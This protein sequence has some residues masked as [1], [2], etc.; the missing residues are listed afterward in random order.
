VGRFGRLARLPVDYAGLAWWGLV[1]PRVVER[2][3]LVVLQAV[4]CSEQGV[5]LAL[6]RELQGWELPGGVACP[7]ETDEEAVRREVHEETGLEVRVGS[8]SG[9]YV[10]T[11]FR[12]HTARV[13]RCRVSGGALRPSEETPRVAWFPTEALPTALL[14][15]FRGPL[16]D[17]MRESSRPVQRCEHQ[18]LGAIFA[19]LRIDLGTRWRGA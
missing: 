19:G 10:R 16:L 4:V 15:W 3:G 17:A 1:S 14:P 5:L 18:G 2:E 7:G 8:L 6:R 12:P 11:G 13:F 9:V